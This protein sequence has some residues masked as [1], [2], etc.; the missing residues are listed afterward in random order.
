MSRVGKRPIKVPK[1]VEVSIKGNE[2]KVK[3][4]KGELSRAFH[5]DMSV[6]LKDGVLSVSRPTD[7]K[8]HRALHG[9]TRS[10]IANMVEGVSQGFK[11]TLELQGVGYRATKSGDKLVIQVG[12]TKPVELAP[13]PGISLAA[14]GPTV[15]SVTGIDKEL[16][17]MFASQIREIKPPD[18]YLGKGIKF[19]GERLRRKAGKA[20]KVG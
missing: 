13:P 10:L 17:G 7:N 4:P 20:G 16:V 14:E 11:K 18:S 12:Y 6:S 15:I 19:A 3:G 9:L 1:G 8:T 5:E 2:I